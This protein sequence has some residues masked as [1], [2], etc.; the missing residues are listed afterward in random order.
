MSTASCLLSAPRP[1]TRV[2]RARSSPSAP[3][4]PLTRRPLG[5]AKCWCGLLATV[6]AAAITSCQSATP[7]ALSTP[8]AVEALSGEWVGTMGLRQLGSC[9]LA[10]NPTLAD[11]ES[12]MKITVLLKIEADGR[13][14]AWEKT[15]PDAILDPLKPRWSGTVS[16]NREIAV[17]KRA[18]AE[19]D[20]RKLESRTEMKGSAFE[21]KAGDS[22]QVSGRETSC[23]SL[24]CV[25]QVYRLTR[26]P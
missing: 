8:V 26:K 24:G 10:G 19:C 7:A 16:R 2:Q 23:P 5:R 6:V 13:L 4:S 11:D 20:G 17:S 12:Q 1:D 18:E 9:S 3:H 22:I 15:R 14:S 25:F 21:G